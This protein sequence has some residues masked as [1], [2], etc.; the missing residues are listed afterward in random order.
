MNHFAFHTHGAAVG[1]AIIAVAVIILCC[2][3]DRE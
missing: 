3:V 2:L 1:L